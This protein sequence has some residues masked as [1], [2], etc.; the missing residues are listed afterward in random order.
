LGAWFAERCSPDPTNPDITGSADPVLMAAGTY[1][2][3]FGTES[4]LPAGTT[5]S[6]KWNLATTDGTQ[7]CGLS[8]CVNSKAGQPTPAPFDCDAM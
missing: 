3:S 2:I 1:I 8:Y 6:Q 7:V 5:F 4:L